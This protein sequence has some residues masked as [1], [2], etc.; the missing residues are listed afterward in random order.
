[1]SKLSEKMNDDMLLC[2]FSESTRT[3]YINCVRRLSKYYNRSPKNISDEEVQKYILFLL[4]KKKLSYSSC[5]CMVSA[6][7]FFYGKTLKY[8]MTSFYIPV[9]KRRQ[10]LP[11][12]PS[13]KEIEKP[14][15]CRKRCK[16]TININAGLWRR[17][18]N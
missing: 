2:G 12:V 6:L 18:K 13:R 15:F 4:K 8:S 9:A 11:V 14:F 17:V 7:K 5:N 10:K 3:V 1:M 16:A